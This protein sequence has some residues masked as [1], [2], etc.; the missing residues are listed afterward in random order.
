MH[1]FGSRVYHLHGKDTDILAEELYEYGH[2]QPATFATPIAYGGHSWRY[3]IPGQGLTRWGKVL[4]ILQEQGYAG[5][6]SIEL[7]DTNF[8]RQVAAEQLGILQGARFL[9]GC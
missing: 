8:D 9:R 4:N 6:V 1:E 7:E 2:E 5:F 3:T